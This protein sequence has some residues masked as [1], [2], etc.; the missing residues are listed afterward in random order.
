[1]K[2]TPFLSVLFTFFTL[3]L[4]QTH[5]A[6]KPILS[7]QF[8]HITEASDYRILVELIRD[9]QFIN[10]CNEQ[11]VARHIVDARVQNG[12]TYQIGQCGPVKNGYIYELRLVEPKKR[13]G[14]WILYFFNDTLPF[15]ARSYV[16]VTTTGEGVIFS[17][18]SRKK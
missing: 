2:I 10:R 7:S 5:A 11:M 16:T 13:F 8:L 3:V 18:V 12:K 17:D 14:P 1:M 9:E 4:S 15:P 6:E